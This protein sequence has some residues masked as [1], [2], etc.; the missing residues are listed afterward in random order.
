MHAPGEEEN[1]EEVRLEWEEV[2]SK[3]EHE[4]SSAR[5][6]AG[7]GSNERGGRLSGSPTFAAVG[8]RENGV[9]HAGTC[10]RNARVVRR[11][12][13]RERDGRLW[14]RRQ[15]ALASHIR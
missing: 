3:Q 2:G 1:E 11:V 8:P 4:A 15:P 12:H 14:R 10:F 13:A 7:D 6:G 9:A 5:G